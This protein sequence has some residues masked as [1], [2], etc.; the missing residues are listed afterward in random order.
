MDGRRLPSPG[1]KGKFPE[2]KR[3]VWVCPGVRAGCVQEEAPRARRA[4][5]MDTPA[6]PCGRTSADVKWEHT[7]HRKTRTQA[8]RE[9]SALRQLRP[10]AAAA[11]AGSA[12]L[13]P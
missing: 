3:G 13:L 8:E 9:E 12:R 2:R 10:A 5:A 1:E 4:T 11:A 7:Q 6:D